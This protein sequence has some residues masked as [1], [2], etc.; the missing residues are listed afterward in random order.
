MVGD[1]GEGDD[2]LADEVRLLEAVPVVDYDEELLLEGVVRGEVEDEELVEDGVE[3]LLDDLGLL[4][5][6]AHLQH[7]ERV[8]EA[9]GVLWEQVGAAD[10]LDHQLLLGSQPRGAP[11]KLE[12]YAFLLNAKR[13]LDL[14]T[15]HINK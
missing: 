6:V 4:L 10:H 12:R 11:T 15:I 5:E 9:V 2:A 8:G 7:H 13:N 3:G 14:S 1:L